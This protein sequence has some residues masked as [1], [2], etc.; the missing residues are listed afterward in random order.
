MSSEEQ[1]GT[2]RYWFP[3]IYGLLNLY[4]SFYVPGIFE[5][6][7]IH[8]HY[9]NNY[10][11]YLM[12]GN[13]TVYE[14]SSTGEHIIDLNDTQISSNF[15][16]KV[17]LINAASNK[18][19]P[20]RLGTNSTLVMK[21]P[22]ADVILIT[23]LSGSMDW[24]MDN[25]NTGN[26]V[27]NCNSPA[28]NNPSTKRISVAKC[29]DM[30]FTDIIMSASGNRMGLVGFNDN[31]YINTSGLGSTRNQLINHINNSYLNNPSGGTC[32][33]CAINRAYQIL[34]EYSDS[35]RQKFIIVMSDGV[36]GY[37]CGIK[38]G[39]CNPTG[40][41]TSGQYS[42]CG[43]QASDCTGN[44]CLGAMQNANYSSCR[45]HKDL[46]ATVHSIGFGPVTN[47]P[48]GN[49]TLRAI[50]SCGNG[51]YN[52]SNDAEG[53]KKIYRDI[54]QKILEIGFKAQIIEVTGT[55]IKNN[56][57]YPDSYIEFNY[58]PTTPKYEYGEISL[59]RE[60]VRLK[61]LT[62]DNLITDAA[63]VTKE[64]WFNISDKVKIVDAK[65]TSYSSE[66]WT[67]RFYL[68]SSKTGGWSNVYWLGS[69]GTNYQKWGDP[70]IVQ[71][72]VNNISTGNN[73]VRIGTGMNPTSGIGGSPDD[74]VI[75]TIRVKGS[76]EYDKTFPSSDLAVADANQRLMDLVSDYVNVLTDDVQNETNS[77]TGVQSLWGPSLL[78]VVTWENKTTY[79]NY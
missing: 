62:G 21:Q 57:I 44:N 24:R 78:K 22:S 5:N 10:T 37:C 74:R 50:A 42:D 1:A 23:D 58:T 14:N 67:D 16:S 40:N 43:G 53:L 2:G 34:N 69:Y 65:I 4:D 72:P 32:I 3:G 73:S 41:S 47:C 71:I 17:N 66:Y 59:T 55:I 61:E 70:F 79:Q 64:G 35:S 76:V 56:T 9:R 77:I 7:S 49:W 8:L 20:I 63:T 25:S 39:S 46:N 75:Y 29:L 28:I 38:S 18:T 30:N 48:N 45:V 27:T 31:A 51:S 13:Y 36:T 54:A 26:I 19:I 33:C 52:A 12:I 6:M 11:T 15:G 60:T 68:N